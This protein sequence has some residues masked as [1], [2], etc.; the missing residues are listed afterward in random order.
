MNKVWRAAILALL[1]GLLWGLFFPAV[2]S[3]ALGRGECNTL[4]S[5]ILARPVAYC[6]LL[7]PTYDTDKARR[8]PILY[9][10]H[11]LGDS[12][13]MFIHSGGMNL[14]NDLWD[15]HQ[16][17]EF[18]I[19]TPAGGASFYINSRDGQRRYEDFF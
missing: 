13:A 7:P 8:Y 5:K 9:F 11:G 15:E 12:E 4:P 14:V 6:V 17:G 2:S 19:V 18:L 16:L 10:L 1:L 3:A